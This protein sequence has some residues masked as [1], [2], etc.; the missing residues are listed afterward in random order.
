M[1][2][3]PY[4]LGNIHGEV[5]TYYPDGKLKRKEVFAEN[6]F[7]EGK[8]FSKSGTD[9]TYFAQEEQPEFVGG[10][11][12]LNKFLKSNLRYPKA[13]QEKGKQGLVVVQFVVKPTGELAD[14]NVVKKLSPELDAEGLR[15][16]KLATGKFKPAR[17]EGTPVSFMYTLPIRFG[18]Q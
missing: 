16:V 9:T 17:I 1:Y 11:L 5:L 6:A 7:V 12:G 10:A 14:F 4:K 3:T 13:A 18:L 15:V 8:C 2:E